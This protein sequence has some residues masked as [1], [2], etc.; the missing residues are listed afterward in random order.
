[1]LIFCCSKF[2]S[3]VFTNRPCSTSTKVVIRSQ[4]RFSLTLYCRSTGG[5]IQ[6]YGTC[7]PASRAR[8]NWKKKIGPTLVLLSFHPPFPF[9]R[10]RNGHCAPLHAKILWRKPQIK[11]CKKL[12]SAHW[13]RS[14]F[15]KIRRNY[16]DMALIRGAI[17][18]FRAE[19][20]K[21]NYGK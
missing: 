12:W 14:K 10:W 5:A 21:K 16:S 19:R 7:L 1:M 11:K 20:G 2:P 6:S 17:H 3:L 18:C 13:V 4:F 9:V 15:T 8:E